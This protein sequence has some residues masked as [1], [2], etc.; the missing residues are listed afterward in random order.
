MLAALLDL[1]GK[2]VVAWAET[3]TDRVRETLD[4]LRKEGH[5]RALLLYGEKG[6]T[7]NLEQT[8]TGAC[9]L[10]ALAAGM[11]EIAL[12]RGYEWGRQQSD[13]ISRCASV[14]DRQC[15]AQA[16]SISEVIECV[17]P[18]AARSL[19]NNALSS[20]SVSPFD[21]KGG[22]QARIFGTAV[23]EIDGVPQRF[24]SMF[25]RLQHWVLDGCKQVIEIAMWPEDDSAGS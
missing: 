14:E 23:V 11:Q 22:R 17:D 3:D 7:Q 24:A 19:I 2:R 10:G 12:D 21:L 5:C 13:L 20:K 9:S 15:V 6:N 4:R 18:A 8:L 25:E 16:Q 1:A